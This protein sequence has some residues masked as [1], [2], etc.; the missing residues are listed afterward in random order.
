MTD[1]KKYS[2][3][4]LIRF[5]LKNEFMDEEQFIAAMENENPTIED[6]E[7]IAK[8]KAKKSEEENKTAHEKAAEEERK[9]LEEEAARNTEPADDDLLENFFKDMNG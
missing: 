4:T 1:V 7:Q 9:Q 2:Q 8:D 6:I 5:L 3:N